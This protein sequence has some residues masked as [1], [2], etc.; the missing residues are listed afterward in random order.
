[1]LM[2]RNRNLVATFNALHYCSLQVTIPKVLTTEGTTCSIG[3]I[4]EL[5]GYQGYI[6]PA[7]S[8]FSLGLNFVI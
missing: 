8:S 6:R 5:R 2:K 7:L 1:M 3:K 4:T